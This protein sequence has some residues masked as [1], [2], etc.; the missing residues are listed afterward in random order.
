M[1]VAVLKNVPV[2]MIVGYAQMD[3]VGKVGKA[4]PLTLTVCWLKMVT[5]SK[6]KF[7]SLSRLLNSY[8]SVADGGAQ[9][10]AGRNRVGLRTPWPASRANVPDDVY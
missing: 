1:V 9:T 6:E 7:P 5:Y 4:N 2:V 10:T 8:N 3:A